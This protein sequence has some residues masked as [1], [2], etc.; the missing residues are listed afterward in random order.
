[1]F[2][3]LNYMKQQKKYLLFLASMGIVLSSSILF[4]E[5]RTP[6]PQ[7]HAVAPEQQQSTQPTEYLSTPT[8]C[9]DMLTENTAT[10][11]T[12][13]YRWE[14]YKDDSTW[15]MVHY[16]NAF[17][18]GELACWSNSLST[19]LYGQ[20]NMINR[21]VQELDGIEKKKGKQANYDYIRTQAK[22]LKEDTA[23]RNMNQGE[24]LDCYG[25]SQ[26]IN[27]RSLTNIDGLEALYPE[28]V[29]QVKSRSN[30]WYTANDIYDMNSW[31][32]DGREF[33]DGTVNLSFP[34]NHP[35]RWMPRW[36]QD[37]FKEFVQRE[38]DS[39][40][41][42]MYLSPLWQDPKFNNASTNP[43][44][45]TWKTL[46]VTYKEWLLDYKNFT[47]YVSNLEK[48][49]TANA[50]PTVWWWNTVTTPP[51]TT[52]RQSDPST[53]LAPQP[54]RQWDPSK[55][56]NQNGTTII[57]LPAKQITPVAHDKATTNVPY[58]L[59]VTSPTTSSPWTSAGAGRTL[60]NSQ[61]T[62]TDTAPTYKYQQQP[63]TTQPAPSTRT[64]RY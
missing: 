39:Y 9:T 16:K 20:K 10:F 13:A 6:S 46:Y 44:L 35:Q 58:I 37:L 52:P 26:Q 34:L 25:N 64:L 38:F 3:I 47:P 33:I 61:T 54:L 53:V 56:L 60:Q 63:T 43:M 5:I 19:A 48:M 8:L 28:L 29:A 42:Q 1:M 32:T 22:K 55:T 36:Q 50:A 11:T 62:T 59:P 40:D 7:E 4:S 18:Q 15:L 51:I 21:F 31:L 57:T 49:H 30:K 17:T 41:A 14:A 2:Y 27:C 23:K 24:R 12:Q 45:D